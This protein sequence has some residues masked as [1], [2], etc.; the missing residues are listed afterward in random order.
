MGTLVI[1]GEKNGGEETEVTNFPDVRSSPLGTQ[2]AQEIY[3]NDKEKISNKGFITEKCLEYPLN[4]LWKSITS[5]GGASR[6]G[7]ENVRFLAI[8]FLFLDFP[9]E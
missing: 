5:T 4:V 8:I 9:P 2:V 7:H 6:R 1:W 3:R